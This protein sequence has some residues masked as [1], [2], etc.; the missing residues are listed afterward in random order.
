MHTFSSQIRQS[1][2]LSSTSH[3]STQDSA[4]THNYYKGCISISVVVVQE[5]GAVINFS[6]QRQ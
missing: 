5:H 1:L 4:N 2:G 3:P 6:F